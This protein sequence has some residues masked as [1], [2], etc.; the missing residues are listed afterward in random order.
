MAKKVVI[1]GSNL[2]TRLS[3]AWGGLNDT[4]SAQ[5]IYGTVVPAGAEWGVNRGEIERFLKAQYG[6]K[7]GTTRWVLGNS[8]LGEDSTFY[9]LDGFAKEEDIT[10]YDANPTEHAELRLF[11]KRLPISSVSSDSYICQLAADVS[12]TP[13]YAKQNGSDFDIHLRYQS[14]YVIA[15]TSQSQNY[16]AYG[17]VTIERSL[18]GGTSWTLV[19]KLTGLSSAEPTATTYPIE[20]KLGKYLVN[21]RVNRF[22]L[23]ASFQYND[24]GTT[25][26]RYSTYVTYNIQTVNLSL[27]MDTN[28]ALPI[29]ANASTSQ[30]ALAFNLFGAIQK[31]LHIE[32]DG[33]QG[34]PLVGWTGSY[35]ASYNG[36]TTGNITLTDATRAFF[37]HGLHEVRAWLTCNDGDGGTLSSSIMTYHLMIYNASTAGADLTKPYLM[38]E[39]MA[40]GVPNFVQSKICSYAVYNAG[41]TTPITL[42]LIIGASAGSI[43]TVPQDEYYRLE[44]TAVQGTKYELNATL[45]I[46]SD[47]P[48]PDAY[49]HVTRTKD[50]VT[51]DFLYESTGFVYQVVSVDN[52]AGY[53]PT[54]GCTFYLNPKLRNNSESNPARILNAKAQNAEIESEW[55]NFKFENQDGWIADDDGNKVLRVPAGSL[56][57]IK[58]NPFAQFLSSPASS[59]TMDFDVCIRNVTN[60]DDPIL[61]LCEQVG[62]NFIGLRMAT[63]TGYLA[64]ASHTA[65]TTSDFRWQEDVRTH[66]AINICNAVAPN[67]GRDGLTADGS[68]PTGTLPM[69]RVFINGGIEREYVFDNTSD[70]EF[71]TAALSNGGF[72]IGQNGADIDIYGIR[73]WASQQ[74][75][76]QQEHQ[77]YI[78]TL[79]TAEAKIREKTQNDIMEGGKVSYDKVRAI[80]KNVLIWHGQEVWHGAS[81]TQVGWLEFYMYDSNGQMIPELSG[82]ICRESASL[83]CKGQGTTA[84]TYYYWNLQTKYS[85][86]EATITIPLTQLHSSI[87]QGAITT[88]DGNRFIALKGGNLGKN[89]PLPTESAQNYP[90]VDVEGVDCVVVPDGW[91]DG[92]GMYRG[93]GHHVATGLPLAQ[94]DVLKI[95]YASGMQSHIVGVNKLYNRLHT[96]FVGKNALQSAVDNAVVAKELEPFLFFTQAT[97]NADILYRGPATWGAGKMDKPTWGYVKSAY[98]NFCMI[99]GADN[100]KELTD[101]RVPFD[102]TVHGTDTY[103]KVYYNP[104]EEAYYYRTQ[105]NLQNSQ[106]SIDFDGGKT[107]EIA[108]VDSTHLFTGEYPHPDIV[109]Y[110]RNTWNFL[111]LHNP[112]IKPYITGSGTLGSFSEFIVSDRASDYGN[113]YWCSDFKLYR[114]DYADRAW[115]SAGLWNGASYDE[116]NLRDSSAQSGSLAYNTYTYWNALST[117]EKADYEGAVNKAFIAGIVAHAK[118]NIGTYFMIDSL[119]FHYVYQNHFIAG[120][121]NCSKNTYYVLVPITENNT[122]VWKFQ[123]HQDDVDTTLATDNSGLQ[124]KPYYI[125]RMHPFA[126]TDIQETDCLYEGRNNA[127]FNLC[128][129][130][131]EGTLE[132]SNALRSVLSLMAGMA[133][134][135]EGSPESQTM[136]GCWGTLN[137]YIF[138]IQRYIPTMAY[139]EAA[140]IRYE[141]PKLLNYVSDQR[142]VDP[143]TQS[144]GRQ[145]EA[146]LQW[147]KRRLVYMASYAAFGE[148]TPGSTSS[149]GLTDLAQSFAMVMAALPNSTTQTS[150][151]KYRLVPHQYLYP[152]AALAQS[153][154]NPHVRVA[155]NAANMPDGYYE[156]TITPTGRSDDGVTVYGINYYRSIGNI[157]DNSFDSTTALTLNGKRLTSFVAEPTIYYST[158]VGGGT[159]T[160]EQWQALSDTEKANYRPA[161]RCAGLQVGTATRLST[162]NMNGC[163]VMGGS[164]V[165]LTKMARVSSIDL[166]GTDLTS[167]IVP[168]SSV[169]TT[170]RLP[171]K[172][173]SLSLTAQP[174]LATLTLDGYSALTQLTITYS[175]LLG[176]TTRGIVFGMKAAGNTITLLDLADI[177]WL[178]LPIDAEVVRWLLSVGDTGICRLAGQIGVSDGVEGRL[179]YADVEALISRYGNIRSTSNPL[180]VRFSSIPIQS[181]A[182]GIE[183]KKYINTDPTSATYD[184]DVNQNFNDLKLFVTL[185][186]DVAVATKQDGTIVPNVVWSLPDDVG[187]IYAEFPDPYS[188]VLHLLQTGAAVRGVKLRV[189]VTLTNTSGEPIEMVKSIGLWN[190]IPEVGDYA[191]I[192]G[193]FDNQNDVSKKLAGLVIKR[194]AITDNDGNITSYKLT[195]LSAA[196]TTFNTS[197]VAGGY[198]SS[199]AP[200]NEV[201]NGFNPS[202]TNDAYNDPILEAIRQATGKNNVFD[203]PLPNQG[204]GYSLIIMKNADA[205]SAAGSGIAMQ[206]ETNTEGNGYAVQTYNTMTN[207]ETKGQ[208]TVLMN[209]ANTVLQAVYQAMNVTIE[210]YAHI[211]ASGGCTSRGVPLTTIGLYQIADMLVQKA[212]DAGATNPARY[213]EFLYLAWR[214]CSVWCPA[215]ITSGGIEENELHESYGRGKWMLPSFGLMSR[216]YNFLGNSRAVYNNPVAPSIEYAEQSEG[217]E[218]P[219]VQLEALK[220]LFANAIARGR[221]IQINTGFVYYSSIVENGQT[222]VVRLLMYYGYI[223]ADLNKWRDSI[224]RA[225]AEFNFLP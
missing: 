135:I 89:F 137:K 189:K 221:S 16:S 78:S 127:L 181:S 7:V 85:D 71:C 203:T 184:L 220:P 11:H 108:T 23:R 164:S 157:G 35:D 115:V 175:P 10:T 42:A 50:G 138:D 39:E 142:Q 57:N 207:F 51:T 47:T 133:S 13:N 100:N 98:P 43:I 154:I 120:T 152:T 9:Y 223:E 60:E 191:W 79:P 110:I 179:T 195:V 63:M 101:M 209:Y 145:L 148:F 41:S 201:A 55:T 19:D 67:S 183:G 46:E 102:D 163:S 96:A 26:T 217:G 105:A 95:N 107:V 68:I 144:M 199:W 53:S 44:T 14:I 167:V 84:K 103:P 165:N 45:E 180:Y 186:N 212:Q 64:T 211:Q 225:V 70:S 66:I 5:T 132:L 75:S 208:N 210:D 156:L 151:Y 206:D 185:G 112:R 176:T 190:R 54:L 33:E 197:V 124:T 171:S 158:T 72:F 218:A 146:E 187:G 25:Q 94:K 166:R 188:P 59:L 202:K 139:N 119:K 169:L 56:L 86:V 30:I 150:V 36:V 117:N 90:L 69:V 205:V 182:M 38:I 109:N 1:N 172:L 213:R 141:F 147:M 58:M 140:R 170:L 76:A 114:Y 161:F 29:T 106:K 65:I 204:G 83:P 214:R 73:I 130:M 121:D 15:A 131:W 173:T 34:N 216:I 160:A 91:I 82:T 77:N 61:R 80:G 37:T 194:D 93:V 12:T 104:S 143:I 178:T 6:T 21:D 17:T 123:L 168:K 128:E 116:V 162:L 99:E 155:P 174:S 48:R 129:E 111:F 3:D 222:G 136:T 198:E 18:N 62:Q 113:K 87:T 28:W 153:S 8:D 193:Q 32:L 4:G 27:N 122:T 134:S 2:L 92:N 125:D 192:D 224:I 219:D 88:E 81:S 74:L 149:T 49:L 118:A 52:T 40:S 159:L 20:V 196:D 126:D 31:T 215:D 97:E 22:R 24:E 177:A 200:Y